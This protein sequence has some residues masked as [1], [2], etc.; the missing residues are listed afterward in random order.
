[1]IH[2]TPKVGCTPEAARSPP[3]SR[4]HL[5]ANVAEPEEKVVRVPHFA[6]FSKTLTTK[7]CVGAT[8]APYP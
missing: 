3:R 2:L 1:M 8:V 4:V 5:A 7:K 6:P